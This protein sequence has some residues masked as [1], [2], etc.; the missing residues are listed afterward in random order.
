MFQLP[1]RELSLE[2][3]RVPEEQ[4]EEMYR[5][6]DT[7]KPLGLKFKYHFEEISPEFDDEEL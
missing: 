1:L 5:I 3:M 4:C 7:E 2:R 6:S